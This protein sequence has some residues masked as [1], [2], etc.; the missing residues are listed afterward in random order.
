MSRGT[1]TTQI[2]VATVWTADGTIYR[3]NDNL[4]FPV[5]SSQ[6]KTILADGA[7]AYITPSTKYRNEPIVFTW[8]F[9]DGTTKD[10]VEGYINAQNDVKI[11]DHNAV[12]YIGLT[13]DGGYIVASRHGSL[14]NGHFSSM[15]YLLKI[16]AQGTKIWSKKY[17]SGS[18]RA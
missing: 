18:R 6:N 17:H 15:I 1:W 5:V 11:I 7:F 10:K 3:P 4:A 2:K 16:D 9:D 8:Y 13:D 12:E 14:A